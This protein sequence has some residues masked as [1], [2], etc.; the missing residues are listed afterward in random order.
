MG[1]FKERTIYCHCGTLSKYDNKWD[2]YY[3][4]KC[5]IWT[6]AECSCIVR[7]CKYKGRPSKPSIEENI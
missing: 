5:G 7:H 1:K 4:P 3:C 6:E 2:S